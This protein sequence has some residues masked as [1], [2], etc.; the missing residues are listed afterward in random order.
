[1]A[2]TSSH[3]WFLDKVH[4]ILEQELT[5]AGMTCHDGTT[6]SLRELETL[7]SHRPN[8]P[9]HGLVLR[10]RLMLGRETLA[11]LPELKWVARSGSGLENIDVVAAKELGIAV[12]SSPEGNRDAVGEHTL[13]MLLNVLHRL[14]SADASIRQ[15]RW[16]REEHRGVEL[17]SL[18]VGIVGYG[19]MGSAFAEKLAGLGCRVLA[20]DKY[21]PGWGE[22]PVAPPPMEHVEPVGWTRFCGEVNVVSLHLPWTAETK[23]LVGDA[24]VRQFANPIVL[25][26]TSRGPIVQTKA[27]LEGLASGRVSWACLDVLE[28][29]G[30]SLEQLEGLE[31]GERVT[32]FEQL[33]AN[34]RVLLSPHVAGWTV[35]S[36]QKLS[37]VLADKIL[38]RPLR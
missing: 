15:R 10:S 18:T 26:N 2:M 1:M 16:E 35:E 14:R 34:P 3:V 30:R 23:G 7:A 25:I 31:S 32:Q 5:S 22:N 11:S 21:K 27:L 4:P 29:E 9:I 8:E 24:W 13:G 19:H 37:T 17:K 20:Y 36:Y 28:Y 38:G 6:L 12:H 33:I